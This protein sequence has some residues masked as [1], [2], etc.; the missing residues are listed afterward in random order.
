MIQETESPDCMGE[1]SPTKTYFALSDDKG[2]F[3]Y[4]CVD[5]RH[6]QALIHLKMLRWSALI[7]K[8]MEQDWNEVLMFCIK[9]GINSLAAVNDDYKDKRW[10]KFIGIFGFPEPT[11]Y[12]VSEVGI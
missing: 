7:R 5:K 6:N 1:A 10:A 12:A 4:L 8:E 3:A 9:N 11:T 2:V